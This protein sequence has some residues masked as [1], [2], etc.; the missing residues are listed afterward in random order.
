[1]HPFFQHIVIVSLILV[2]VPRLGISTQ[3]IT[4]WIFFFFAVLRLQL[5]AF[6][7]SHSTSPIFC[8][9]VFQNSVS[10][11]IWLG[12]L[13]TVILLISASWAASATGMRHWC[14]AEIW[15]SIFAQMNLILI[16]IRYWYLDMNAKRVLKVQPI[17]EVGQDGRVEAL[18]LWMRGVGIAEERLYLK[19][20]KR[21]KASGITKGW[22]TTGKHRETDSTVK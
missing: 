12:W 6:T 18:T 13:Q 2:S 10:P 4:Q 16:Y 5:R 20:R 22:Q 19:E 15:T 7:L 14:L 21:R 8:D 17:E 3:V 9:R 1:M 11:T